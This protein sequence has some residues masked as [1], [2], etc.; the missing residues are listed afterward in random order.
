MR[1]LDRRWRVRTVLVGLVLASLLPGLIVAAFL[2]LRAY[3]A[4]FEQRDK[5]NLAAARMLVQAVD[6]EIDKATVLAL[7]L[8]TANATLQGDLP[9]LHA[10]S[11]ELLALARVGRNVVLTEPSGRQVLNTLRPYGEPLPP[12]GNQDIARRV[13][14]TG[15]T[16]MSDVYLGGVLQ[17]PVL[18][19]DVPV[20]RE[21]RVVYDLSV[22]MLPEDFAAIV[23]NAG[24]PAEW[25]VA[26]FDRSG[27]IVVRS[28]APERF[29]GSGEHAALLERIRETGE[30]IMATTTLEGIEVM[31]AYA[32]S[33]SSGWGVAIGVPRALAQAELWRPL[34]DLVLVFT[35]LFA[36]GVALATAAAR[37]IARSMHALVGPAAALASGETFAPPRVAIREAE[38]VGHAISEAAGILAERT[39]ALQD[40]HAA[41]V[42][43]EAELREAQRIARVG[44]WHWSRARGQVE[45][46]DE[47]REMFGHGHCKF[48]DM[49]GGI[50]PID[51][52]KRADEAVARALRTRESFELQLAVNAAGG[53][54]MWAEVKGKPLLDAHGE[55][56][57]LLGTVQ[58]ITER[59]RAEDALRESDARFHDELVREVAER[60]AQLGEAN[61]ALERALRRDALTGLDNRLSANERLRAEFLRMKRGASGFSVL[62]VDIDRFK[63]INDFFGHAT[64]DEVL[65]SFAAI[66]RKCLGERDFLARFGGGEFVA[67][68]SGTGLNAAVRLAETIRTAVATA[69]FAHFGA[70][71]AT[72]GVT[73]ARPGDTSEADVVRRADGA[74]CRAKAEGRNAV[75]VAP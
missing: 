46:S 4:G 16:V 68:V 6:A 32:R 1:W 2:L 18:S 67:I 52:W 54:R 25:I 10:R 14:E 57:V 20:K 23:T 9:A 36:A 28:H 44:A 69:Q 51:D 66:V 5:D 8:A 56:A 70:V 49:R 24:L 75:R 59:K 27:T 12:H 19:V 15:A 71:T 55:V 63:S 60:T 43:R 3:G 37:S 35:L 47:V 40:A 73:D 13:F 65:R 22:G 21:G 7:T 11:R 39:R 34:R 48:T 64:G 30:G 26:I 41:L 62:L 17:V 38:E 29:V 50:L 33:A 61:R 45:V 72:I 53:G 42:G 31:A 58:D 74:L